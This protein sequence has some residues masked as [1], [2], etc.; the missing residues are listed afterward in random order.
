MGPTPCDGADRSDF[1]A[2][3]AQAVSEAAAVRRR[4]PVTADEADIEHARRPT[5]AKAI[6]GSG[7]EDASVI[8]QNSE[9][10]D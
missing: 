1:V 9:L 4:R 6:A 2:A 5:E 8:L 3:E 10:L 7:K